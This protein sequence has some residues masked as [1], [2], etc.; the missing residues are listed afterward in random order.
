MWKEKDTGSLL[1]PHA[2]AGNEVLFSLMN[3]HKVL[4][5]LC[6]AVLGGNLGQV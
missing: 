3:C 5:Q 4:K 1:N 6:T 2:Q